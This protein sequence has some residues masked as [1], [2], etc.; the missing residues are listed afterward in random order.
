MKVDL[1][2]DWKWRIDLHE[3]SVEFL[4][5]LAAILAQQAVW[6]AEEEERKK[7]ETGERPYGLNKKDLPSGQVLIRTAG[8]GS[9]V[10]L[11]S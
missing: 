10:S 1:E 9:T 7:Q 3:G 11:P 6:M 5:G 8:T 2:S 4:D